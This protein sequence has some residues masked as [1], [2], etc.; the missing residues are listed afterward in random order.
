MMSGSGTYPKTPHQL[1]YQPFI[2][3]PHLS[4]DHNTGTPDKSQYKPFIR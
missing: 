2:E 4:G 1:Y 3:L